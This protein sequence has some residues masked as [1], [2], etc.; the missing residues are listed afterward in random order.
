MVHLN[1]RS[2]FDEIV[3]AFRQW[4]QQ[5][6]DEHGELRQA[7]KPRPLDQA[8]AIRVKTGPNELW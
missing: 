5:F 1:S 6:L 4:R 7:Y 8:A 2:E 3:A